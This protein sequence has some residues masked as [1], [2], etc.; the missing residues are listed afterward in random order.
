MKDYIL[1]ADYPSIH[2]EYLEELIS[3]IKTFRRCLA[4]RVSALI[5]DIGTCAF[6]GYKRTNPMSK[7]SSK[8]FD[9]GY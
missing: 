3:I 2:V 8:S 9:D 1:K 7:A 5:S 4:H 6:I